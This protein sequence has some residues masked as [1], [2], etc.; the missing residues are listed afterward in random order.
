MDTPWQLLEGNGAP[1]DQCSSARS[2]RPE[3]GCLGPA[4]SS[5]ST[6]E[7]RTVP[8]SVALGFRQIPQM[9]STREKGAEMIASANLENG[10]RSGK[11]RHVGS[12]GPGVDN[13]G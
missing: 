9:F 11:V 7:E 8:L 1:W 5:A 12:A 3:V 4:F 10:G 2:T 13:K 6:G